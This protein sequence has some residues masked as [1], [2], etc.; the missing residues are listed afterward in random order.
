[1]LS[2]LFFGLSLT[3]QY[4]FSLFFFGWF[5][6]KLSTH[7]LKLLC[8]LFNNLIIVFLYFNFGDLHCLT[9]EPISGF[10][11]SIFLVILILRGSFL[12]LFNKHLSLLL[13]H[14]L[15]V[16]FGSLHKFKAHDSLILLLL[17]LLLRLGFAIKIDIYVAIFFIITI[18]FI[19]CIIIVKVHKL[20]LNLRDS[21]LFQDLL[22]FLVCIR[23]L[24]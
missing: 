19:L 11:K 4:R 20:F 22:I 10:D 16:L 21:F 5:N 9:A 1:M 13:G 15:T 7:C 3:L 23:I 14:L 17:L 24:F 8:C 6:L 18:F 2:R 12:D